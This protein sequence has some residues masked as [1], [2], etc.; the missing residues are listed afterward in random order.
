[1][2]KPS[3]SSHP[4][5]FQQYIDQ[6]PEENM[7]TAFAN[8][9][10]V[11]EPFLSTISE[12]KSMTAYAEGKWTLKELLQHVIDCERIF[13]YRSLAIARDEKQNL[14]GFDEDLYADASH[15]NSRSWNSL[16][17][18]FSAVRKSTEMLFSSFN[19]EDLNKSGLANNKPVSVAS[20]AFIILGHWYHHKRIIHERYL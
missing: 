18:E 14:P 9:H 20:L 16:I 15:S 1:M 12:E 7:N 17:E 8:Q 6:V 5:Y 19:E 11:I 4:E 13:N 10:A 3:P 2:P